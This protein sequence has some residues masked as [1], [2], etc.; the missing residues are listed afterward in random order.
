VHTIQLAK[1]YHHDPI[2]APKYTHSCN[3]YFRPCSLIP[4]CYGDDD[5]QRQ[6]LE[7]MVDDEWSPLNKLVLD[8]VGNE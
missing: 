7:E 5:E 4:F 8:G 1:L 3:R 6:F 2:N